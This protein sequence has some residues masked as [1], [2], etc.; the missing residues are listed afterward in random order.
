ME[1]EREITVDRRRKWCG[2]MWRNVELWVVGGI[3]DDEDE[4]IKKKILMMD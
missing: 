3:I 1:A 4:M 2:S